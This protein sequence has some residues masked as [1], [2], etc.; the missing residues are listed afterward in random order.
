MH[1]IADLDRGDKMGVQLNRGAKPPIDGV[2]NQLA[3]GLIRE[4]HQH[5]AMHDTTIVT[6]RASAINAKIRRPSSPLSRMG[7][8]K[9][10]KSFVI[11]GCH[12]DSIIAA[13]DATVSKNR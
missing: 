3:E 1:Q 5:A 4:C 12:S 13:H 2:W 7:P 9:C 6:W 8:T 10:G 11:R